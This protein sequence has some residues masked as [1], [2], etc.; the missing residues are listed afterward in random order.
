M[1]V[2]QRSLT[3]PTFSLTLTEA[4]FLVMLGTRYTGNQLKS[5]LLAGNKLVPSMTKN[6]ASGSKLIVH[7]TSKM[8]IV[9]GL[10]FLLP[11]VI[12]Q[13]KKIIILVV[14]LKMLFVFKK[15]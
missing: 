8:E 1:F 6:T 15:T 4:V 12:S 2:P 10:W 11:L 7:S 9:Y 5:S 14:N 13:D 3:S